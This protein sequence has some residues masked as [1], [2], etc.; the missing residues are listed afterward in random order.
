MVTVF[1]V[2]GNSFLN[3]FSSF[4]SPPTFYRPLLAPFATNFCWLN[5]LAFC[6]FQQKADRADSPL[7]LGAT[8]ENIYITSKTNVYAFKNVTSQWFQ[9]H[10]TVQKLCDPRSPNLL[11]NRWFQR[12][13]Y[14]SEAA[15]ILSQNI[16]ATDQ[17]FSILW[18]GCGGGWKEGL[19]DKVN[20]LDKLCVQ[21]LDNLPAPVKQNNIIQ[22]VGP[23]IP[24]IAVEYFR[25]LFAH[26]FY[27]SSM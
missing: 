14:W 23:D 19:A 5:L 22:A 3:P 21:N 9:R 17:I 11:I 13:F 25:M 27:L 8:D 18:S 20:N 2:A 6:R 7:K 24:T 10:F 15:L 1:C 26:I 16:H 4:P 12:H